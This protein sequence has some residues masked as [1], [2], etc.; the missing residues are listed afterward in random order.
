[1]SKDLTGRER[2]VLKLIAEGFT[3]RRIAVRLDISEHTAK[4]HVA[5]TIRKLDACSRAEAAAMAVRMGVA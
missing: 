5:N 1:M 2:E 4:F 3:N